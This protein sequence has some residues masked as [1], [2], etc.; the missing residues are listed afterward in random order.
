MTLKASFDGFTYLS[1]DKSFAWHINNGRSEPYSDDG[2]GEIGIVNRFLFLNPE[3]NKTYIDVGAH[4]GTTVMPYSRLFKTVYA[5][6]ANK[7]SYDLLEQNVKL[8]NINN[9]IMQNIAISN[10]NTNGEM[11][12]HGDNSGCYYFKEKKN[13]EGT[14]KS[15]IL[16]EQNI[17][18]ID[19]IKIDTEGSELL[20]L[21]GAENLLKKYKPLIH[22]EV[23]HCSEKYFGINKSEIHNY[24]VSL[25]FSI[26]D[27]S[28]IDNI[29]Y[30]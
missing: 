10:K 30:F 13:T 12:K 7:E 20:V 21:Q 2:F 16:D 28:Y 19:F 9:V 23:N 22:I 24:L 3:R 26:F 25:G 29:F 15:I 11:V 27:D 8:N 17:T 1:N 14:V 6:E 4:I 5:F 18:D